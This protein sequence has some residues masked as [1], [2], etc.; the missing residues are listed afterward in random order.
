MAYHPQTDRQTKWVNQELE[1]YLQIFI[2]E[3]QDNWYILLPLVEF[4]YN[5][6][7]LELQKWH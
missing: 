2:R 5:N 4:S 7:V 3:Q 6:H 1:Q